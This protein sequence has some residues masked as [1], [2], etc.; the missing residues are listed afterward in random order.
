MFDSRIHDQI[1]G[2]L[3]LFGWPWHGRL[4]MALEDNVQSLLTLVNGQVVRM[5]FVT[6][7]PT[8]DD[9]HQAGNLLRFRDPRAVDPQRTPEQIEADTAQGMQWRAEALI[10]PREG[11]IYGDRK[12]VIKGLQWVYHHP[13]Y[14]N[15]RAWFYNLTALAFKPHERIISRNRRLTDIVTLN[16]RYAGGGLDSLFGL[17]IID[18]YPD[19][20]RLLLARYRYQDEW[21]EGSSS[22]VKNHLGAWCTLPFEYWE[23]TLTPTADVGVDAVL[24]LIRNSAQTGGTDTGQRTTYA[25]QSISVSASVAVTS[26]TATTET[27]EASVSHSMVSNGAKNAATY[28]GEDGDFI[29][30]NRYARSITGIIVNMYYDANGAPAEI[31]ANYSESRTLTGSAMP[32]ASYSPKAV[33]TRD[34]RVETGT[35]QSA[36]T[37]AYTINYTQSVSGSSTATLELLRAGKVVSR[38]EVI[39]QFSA[40]IS[41]QMGYSVPIAYSSSTGYSAYPSRDSGSKSGT[42]AV[43]VTATLDGVKIMEQSR[44]VTGRGVDYSLMN[45]AHFPYRGAKSTADAVLY[46]VRYCAQMPALSLAQCKNLSAPNIVD[47]H[48]IGPC[49]LPNGKTAPGIASRKPPL[50]G[51]F[52]SFNPVTGEAIRDA[53]NPVAYL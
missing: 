13:Q 44:S 48:F 16:L 38:L 10:N 42:T 21:G 11:I 30:S 17:T 8:L 23:L 26:R 34:T 2:Q 7:P 25:G 19:G 43:N 4:D 14:G 40:N 3:G 52:G 36:T 45:N 9:W 50:G 37:G 51:L 20:S 24:T 39:G 12:Q 47:T 53:P 15:V 49:L 33:V 31:L 32:S 18:A 22:F 41:G 28:S 6:S 5:P 35:F 27:A 46:V 29:Q 1:P